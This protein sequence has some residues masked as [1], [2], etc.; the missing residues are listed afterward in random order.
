MTIQVVGHRL[1]G[2]SIGG[3]GE[4]W[5]MMHFLVF[6]VWLRMPEDMCLNGLP[7]Q[8]KIAQAEIHL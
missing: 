6:C 2:P 5:R 8:G 7:L 3:T 4:F 1:F